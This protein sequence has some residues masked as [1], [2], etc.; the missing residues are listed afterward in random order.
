MPHRKYRSLERECQIQAVITTHPETKKE[1]KKME[2]EY[3][4]I[5]DWLESHQQTDQQAPSEK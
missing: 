2:R 5:A 3:N 4:A 1:I